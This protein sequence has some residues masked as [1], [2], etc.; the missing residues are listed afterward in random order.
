MRLKSSLLVAPLLVVG[1]ALPA[2]PI[3]DGTATV[4]MK[5]ARL[6][7]EVNA[8]DGDG[9]VQL[10]IDADQWKRL[11]VFDP[12]GRKIL[13]TTTAGAMA[14]Q[15]G[16]ELFLESAEPSFEDLPLEGLLERFPAGEYRV[17]GVGLDG[18]RLVGTA[19]LTHDIPDG[20]ILVSPVEGDPPQNPDGTTLVWESV[21]PTNGS[22]IIG[23]QVLAV[24]SETGFAALPKVTLDVTMPATATS[25]DIPPGF[26][27]SG[28]QYEWEV[29]AIEE[30][31]NQSLSSSFFTTST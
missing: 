7:F 3:P 10:F 5:D 25:F 17:R 26:L 4:A 28:A 13:V 8:T 2:Q 1:L 30:G 19:V 6:K 14:E 31:G 9:G 11:A 16:T 12:Q 23:Y 18:E 21:E 20:P 22:P 27:R 29:L 24:L 15:G